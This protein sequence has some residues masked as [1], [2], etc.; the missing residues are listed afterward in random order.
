MAAL[1]VS[2]N[3]NTPKICEAYNKPI[4]IHQAAGVGKKFASRLRRKNGQEIFSKFGTQVA[5]VV[6][7]AENRYGRPWAG[8]EWRKNQSI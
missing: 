2:V 8:N 3:L 5:Y 7:Y 1:F 6:T 4:S